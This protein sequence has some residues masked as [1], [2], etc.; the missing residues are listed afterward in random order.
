MR[1]WGVGLAEMLLDAFAA[2][3]VRHGSLTAIVEGDGTRVSFDELAA[4]AEGF[5]ALWAVRG[6]GQGD[7]VLLAMPIGAD[8]YAALA[9]IWSL[10]ATAVLPEPAMGLAGV[11]Y[12]LQL[13]DCQ[14]LVASGPYV[15]LKLLQPRLWFKPFYRAR[16]GS[17]TVPRAPVDAEDIALVSFTSGSTGVPKA[18]PRSHGFLQAQRQAVAPLLESET[19]EVDLVAFP[20]FVLINL[21][22]GRCSVLPNWSMSRLDR[23][24]PKALSEWIGSQQ[25]TRALL[26]PALVDTLAGGTVP[27]C[28]HTVFTGGGPVFPDMVDRLLAA[29]PDLR[30]VTVYGSTEAEPI[31]ELDMGDVSE[32]D[33]M[34]MQNGKGLLAGPPVNE[35]DLRIV[36]GEIVV[37]GDHVNRGYLDPARDVET[38]IKDGDRVWHRTGDAGHLDEDGRVWLLGRHGAEVGGH[39]PFAVETAARAWPG[40]RRAAL[41]GHDGAPVLAV[42]GVEAHLADWQAKAGA[43]GIPDVRPV[44]EIPLDRRHR[45]KVDYPRLKSIVKLDT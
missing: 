43:L 13:A 30:V 45:S 6:L 40:V 20:V 32:A 4:R 10:G 15:W 9:A 38:K 22:A 1:L 7:R 19:Q 16:S 41:V 26:P 35:L 21:A 3:V 17:G 11:R 29:R 27:A 37:A 5:A 39:Y 25:V 33:R 23:V 44:P 12:A 28:L 2:A 36:D 18:I 24:T 14:G 34:A 42:E 31:A 8:L